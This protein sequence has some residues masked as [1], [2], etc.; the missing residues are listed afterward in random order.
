[1][2]QGGQPP[3]AEIAGNLGNLLD[4]GALDEVVVGPQLTSYGAIG[5][6]D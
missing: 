6:Q 1:M 4:I 3:A 5:L 2:A